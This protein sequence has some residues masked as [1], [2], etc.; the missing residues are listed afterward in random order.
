[1]IPSICHFR[2]GKIKNEESQKL[3]ERGSV[4]YVEHRGFP[5]QWEYSLWY[6]IYGYMSLYCPNS[7][8]GQ[9]QEWTVM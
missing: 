8:N 7:L 4:K 3:G 1:M 6:Y 9:Y 2:E 5:G